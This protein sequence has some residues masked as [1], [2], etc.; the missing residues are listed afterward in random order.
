[1]RRNPDHAK[2]KAQILNQI[3]EQVLTERNVSQSAVALRCLLDRDNCSRLL[4]ISGEQG[5]DLDKDEAAKLRLLQALHK[6]GRQTV[7]R[8][9]QIRL[10]SKALTAVDW[11]QLAQTTQVNPDPLSAICREIHLHL[12][13]SIR[14]SQPQEWPENMVNSRWARS[15]TQAQFENGRVRKKLVRKALIQ[16]PPDGLVDAIR[17]R[18]RRAADGAPPVTQ[19]ACLSIA[20]YQGDFRPLVCEAFLPDQEGATI[21]TFV[22]QAMNGVRRG[23]VGATNGVKGAIRDPVNGCAERL[24]RHLWPSFT[25]ETDGSRVLTDLGNNEYAFNWEDIKILPGNLPDNGGG[26]A[27]PEERYDAYIA[28]RPIIPVRIEEHTAQIAKKRGAAYQRA[29]ASG[30]VNVLSCSTTFEMGVNLGDLTC[31]FLANLPPAV[32]NY[33]Q[34][35]GRAGRRPGT[36]AYVLSFVGSSPHDQYFFDHPAQLLFGAVQRLG[37]IWRTAC[38]S[39]VIFAPKALH[40]F[41]KWMQ[42]HWTCFCKDPQDNGNTKPRSRK[43]NM[44]GDFFVG[45]KTGK[46]AKYQGQRFYPITGVFKPLVAE[47][48]DWHSQ[49]ATNVQAIVTSIADVPAELGYDVAADLVWQLCTQE[50]VAPYSLEDPRNSYAFRQLAGP[51]QPED[52]DDG[53]RLRPDVNNPAP[54][55]AGACPISVRNDWR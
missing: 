52:T 20:D 18:L 11:S 42:D 26:E 19:R 50:A 28:T 40:E 7:L 35:A 37:S 27:S 24:L 39:R 43:W 44:V 34:R 2:L 53:L 45:R 29:F 15:I 1:M 36:A 46:F 31:V 30:L 13:E 17:E 14:L 12:F 51:N 54:G 33:R 48:P 16:N 49:Q 47:L 10:E 41:L 22:Q 38:S 3:I 6:K 9:K 55:G 4:E 32:A 8:K 5:G 23:D 25:Q 21:V